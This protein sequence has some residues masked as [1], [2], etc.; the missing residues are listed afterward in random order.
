MPQIMLGYQFSD[1]AEQAGFAMDSLKT[2]F[3]GANY[4]LATAFLKM[5][6][7]NL[8]GLANA[9][10]GLFFVGPDIFAETPFLVL[11]ETPRDSWNTSNK[12]FVN[13][14]KESATGYVSK[15]KPVLSPSNLFDVLVVNIDV[16]TPLLNLVALLREKG[17]VREAEIAQYQ[18]G[19]LLSHR[20]TYTALLQVLRDNGI[21]DAFNK[22]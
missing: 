17:F 1:T 14:G 8:M 4:T 15:P 16:V 3:P 12:Q 13:L 6:K 2:T 21:F 22:I 5:N 11:G 19:L 10:T 18:L 20:T 7:A 9:A